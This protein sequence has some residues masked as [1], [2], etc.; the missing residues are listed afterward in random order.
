MFR[1]IRMRIR[2][3]L[4]EISRAWNA[5]QSNRTHVKELK[6]ALKQDR[7]CKHDYYRDYGDE[8]VF[9]GDQ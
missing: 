5:L 2:N 4:D 8:D 1:K 7:K 9:F 3:E 6:R